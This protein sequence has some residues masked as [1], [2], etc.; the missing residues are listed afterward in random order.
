V[1]LTEEGNR[2][3]VVLNLDDKMICT[4]PLTRRT[5]RVHVSERFVER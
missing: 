1:D 4:K 3:G 5:L 2:A